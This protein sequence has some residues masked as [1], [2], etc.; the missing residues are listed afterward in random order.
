LKIA[1]WTTLAPGG[2]ASRTPIIRARFEVEWGKMTE[3]TKKGADPLIK[4]PL[5]QETPKKCRDAM[6]L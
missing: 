2:F 5:E 4:E 3:L 1:I 6:N